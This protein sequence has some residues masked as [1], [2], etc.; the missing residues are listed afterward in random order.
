MANI[1][2]S[3]KRVAIS[4]ANAQV[5]GVVAGAAFVT[6]FCLMASK[7]VLS[8]NAYIG[9]VI[10]AKEKAHNQLRSN[11]DNYDNLSKSYGA[12]DNEAVNKIGGNRTG[13]GDNDGSNSKIIL[14][15]LPSYYDFPALTSSL[16]KI[17][18]DNNITQGSIT[19]TDDQ[20]AQQ[21]NA[22]SPNPE[23]VSIPFTFSATK[24]NYD[25]VQKLVSVFGRSIRPIQVDSMDISG[26]SADMSVTI[27]AHTFYQPAKD[28]NITTQVQK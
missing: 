28:V 19:G 18:H 14:D 1:E 24:M 25:G 17:M 4:K 20:V 13:E 6:I 2:L 15:A 26:G 23:A 11:L 9:R 10:S 27:S 22:T 7:A 5:V 21:T 12:F 3:S 8:Q 16:E